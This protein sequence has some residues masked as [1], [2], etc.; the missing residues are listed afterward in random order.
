MKHLRSLTAIL[1]SFVVS[2]SSCEKKI[3]IP[4]PQG[5]EQLVLNA[6]MNKDSIIYVRLTKLN[7]GLSVNFK[8]EQAKEVRLY[9][10]GV[11]KETLFKE[12]RN[13]RLFYRSTINAVEGFSYKI[14]AEMAEGKLE[15]EDII[16]G[17]VSVRPGKLSHETDNEGNEQT[18]L[19][20]SLTDQANT[21]NYYRF[22]VF[23]LHTSNNDPLLNSFSVD[24]KTELGSDLTLNTEYTA[25]FTD[26][27]LFDAQDMSYT[28]SLNYTTVDSAIVEITALSEA[29]YK[30]LKSSYNAVENAGNP[31]VEPSSIFSNIQ[32]G[33]GIVGGLCV[34][35]IVIK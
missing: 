23:Q 7:P 17:S 35:R 18:K 34:K 27:E 2:L 32:N 12:E 6:L 31:F 26:D 22:R 14:E 33:L 15:G 29:S 4:L 8:E 24:G 9:E 10:N 16:P 11:F 25:F 5:A 19:Q 21:R 20:F 1:L 30:Y 3:D 13:G 28:L